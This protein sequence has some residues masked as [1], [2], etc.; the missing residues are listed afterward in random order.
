MI[1]IRFISFILI[2]LLIII[3]SVIAWSQNNDLM[4]ETKIDSLS[5][6]KTELDSLKQIEM[7]TVDSLHITSAENDSLSAE[8]IID[9]AGSVLETLKNQL[10]EYLKEKRQTH[11][12]LF[13]PHLIYKE[14]FHLK[15]PFDPA[16]QFTK[17]GFTII[18]FEVSNTHILQ[19]YKPFFN[20]RCVRDNI[21]FI[22]DDYDLPVA[23]SESYLGLGDFDMN[24]VTATLKKGNILGIKNLHFEGD[25]IG[26]DGEWLGTR[27]QSRNYN[28]HLFCDLN[29]GKIHFYQTTIDQ[30]IN[31]NV[32]KDAPEIPEKD[33]IKEWISDSAILFE[34]RFINIGGLIK[35]T[36]IDTM[37]RKLSEIMLTKSIKNDNNLLTLTYEY[38]RNTSVDSTFNIFSLNQSSDIYRFHLGN[39]GYFQNEDNYF[40]S[41]ELSMKIFK[42]ISLSVK[43]LTRQETGYRNL[44]PENRA[45]AGLIISPSFL[46]MEF[47]Y[48][49][50]TF[51]NSHGYESEDIRFFEMSN[52]IN[53]NIRSFGINLKRWMLYRDVMNLYLPTW[54]SKTILEV[55]YNMPYNN[56]IKLGL[57]HFY[58]SEYQFTCDGTDT[59]YNMKNLNLDAYLAFQI[60]DR[61]EIKLDAVNLTN[62]DHLFAYPSSSEL[63]EFHVNFN[64]KWIFVN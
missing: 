21:F 29:W 54:Q 4:I 5:L 39:S 32:L 30:K 14:N 56:S 36:E 33:E 63:P 27:E 31:P 43:H 49:T 59:I 16:I 11:R 28:I 8:A 2:N 44:E 41:S 9:T 10:D 45:G 47:I 20:T 7:N 17:N 23:F 51:D 62:S 48:G 26:Q 15:S 24:H 57:S 55:I 34:N 3:F 35:T 12:N 38:F 61:F 19:N 42:P 60:T 18:P 52:I 6:E 50:E 37:K 13:I 1:K 53:F 22:E 46:R 58:T 64:V 25:Y 40:L